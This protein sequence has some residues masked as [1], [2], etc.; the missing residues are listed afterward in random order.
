VVINCFFILREGRS[1]SETGNSADQLG[2]AKYINRGCA[3]G[4]VYPRVKAGQIEA[5]KEKLQPIPGDGRGVFGVRC[6]DV[7]HDGI[8]IRIALKTSAARIEVRE[9]NIGR[10]R[11]RTAAEKTVNEVKRIAIGTDFKVEIKK[12]WGG[13]RQCRQLD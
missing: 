4:S 5:V 3:G 6:C 8:G 11:N 9:L 10:I 1:F 2:W 12:P 13:E 7:C